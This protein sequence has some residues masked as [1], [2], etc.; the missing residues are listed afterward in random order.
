M[1]KYVNTLGEF[2]DLIEKY[3]SC[4]V[5]VTSTEFHFYSIKNV[6][7]LYIF[8]NVKNELLLEPIYRVNDF[9]IQIKPLLRENKINKLKYENKRSNNIRILQSYTKI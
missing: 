6:E 8:L 5:Y 9:M 7:I 2:I 1:V 3:K 4:L